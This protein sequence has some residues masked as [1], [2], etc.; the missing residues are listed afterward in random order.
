MNSSVILENACSKSPEFIATEKEVSS[1]LH[2]GIELGNSSN[3]I[4]KFYEL[5]ELAQRGQVCVS[6][7]GER[8]LFYWN[9][10]ALEKQEKNAIKKAL[11]R[12]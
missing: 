3:K 7:E 10:S 1:G 9:A 5:V 11:S 2:K 12:G 6:E 4:S 8:S